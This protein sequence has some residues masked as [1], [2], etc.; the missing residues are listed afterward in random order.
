M[1]KGERQVTNYDGPL[2]EMETVKSLL[3]E[4]LFMMDH[5][6]HQRKI[7]IY[8]AKPKENIEEVAKNI[9]EEKKVKTEPKR[10]KPYK[11]REYVFPRELK[12]KGYIDVPGLSDRLGSSRSF[13][14]NLCKDDE[15]EY[16]KI[17][18]RYFFS[19]EHVEDFLIYCGLNPA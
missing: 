9:C 15:I 18:K 3:N 11:K 14:S 16:V 2:A 17:G 12:E 7:E 5:M 13:I 8:G 6:S 1:E 10:K 19:P 4:C